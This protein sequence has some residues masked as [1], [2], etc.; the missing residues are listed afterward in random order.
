VQ[1]SFKPVAPAVAKSATLVA[2]NNSGGGPTTATQSVALTGTAT[3]APPQTPATGTP[4]IAPPAPRIGQAITASIGTI[5]DVNGVGTL[6]FQWQATTATGTTFANIAGATAST[7]TPPLAR[8]CQSFRVQVTFTDGLGH[9]EGPLTSVPTARAT[10][11]GGA[12]C[13]ALPPVA[14]AAAAPA[15]APAATPLGQALAPLLSP[16]APAPR[17]VSVTATSSGPI[18]VA[19]TVPAGAGIV[20]IS[21]F[22]VQAPIKRTSSTRQGPKTV[23]VAT[24]LR[25]TTK[26]KR[27]VFRLTEKPFRHLKPGRYLVQVRVGR[28]AA[29]L[30]PPATRQIT[31][32]ARRSRPAR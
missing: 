6:H 17:R 15:T 10:I 8:L 16:P 9:A 23:H 5:A 21:L 4:S 24:V 30:G 31:I 27:Y 19:A 29:T 25:K 32:R 28:S 22:R 14:V 12:L 11:A 7:F 18:A 13:S 26:A 2:T 1:V 3:T 20:S